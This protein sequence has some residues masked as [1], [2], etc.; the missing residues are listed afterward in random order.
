MSRALTRAEWGCSVNRINKYDIASIAA[1][2]DLD[3]EGYQ[4]LPSSKQRELFGANL[5][6]RK[7]ISF[8][9]SDQ[10]TVRIAT[11]KAFGTDCSVKRLSYEQFAEHVNQQERIGE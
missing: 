7:D 8:D 9:S 2:N 1:L 10:G 5:V 6:G 11:S 4:K 3:S